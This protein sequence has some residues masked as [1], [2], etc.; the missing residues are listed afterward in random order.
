MATQDQRTLDKRLTIAAAVTGVIVIAEVA[1]GILSNSLALLSDS[2]HAFADTLALLLALYGVRQARRQGTPGMTFGYH[3]V[4]IL[5]ALLNATLLVIVAGTIIFEAVRRLPQPQPVQGLLMF[6]IALVGL[7]ANLSVALLLHPFQ[8]ESLAVRS[9]LFNVLGDLLGSMAVI[10][11][12]ITIALTGFFLIDPLASLLIAGIMLFGAIIIMRDGLRVLLEASPKG[13]RVEE[14]VDAMQKISGVKSVHDLHVWS[15][16]H[17]MEAV[18]CHIQIDEVSV[19]DANHIQERVVDVLRNQYDI[20][21]STLQLECEH[22]GTDDLYCSVI[23]QAGAERGR[24]RA[25]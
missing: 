4:G 6:S 16:T 22:S 14:V 24:D 17:G 8:R 21:H 9:A 12:G 2:G 18:S 7:A 11:G 3:R 15:I 19:H 10:L 5:I 1:G 13:L 20:A 23:L 25:S